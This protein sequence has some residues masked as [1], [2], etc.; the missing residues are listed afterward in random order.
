MDLNQKPQGVVGP[1]LFTDDPDTYSQNGYSDDD[2][3]CCP[4]YILKDAHRPFKIH[5]SNANLY[6][7]GKL[8][9]ADTSVSQPYY[10][11]GAAN[12]LALGSL[13]FSLKQS[14]STALPN[15]RYV[16]GMMI[17]EWEVMFVSIKT[18]GVS[19]SV[20][21]ILPPPEVPEEEKS[22]SEES[23]PVTVPEKDP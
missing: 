18:T 23:V 16:L 20:S 5:R 17:V 10:S 11:Q 6:Q 4:T 22:K 21:N 12:P 8:S 3:V 13:A 2:R 1:F 14:T 19:R 7:N 9:V 15:N